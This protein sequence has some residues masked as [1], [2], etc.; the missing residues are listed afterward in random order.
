MLVKVYN[1][2]GVETGTMELSDDVFGCAYNEALVHQA[3]VTNLCNKRQGTKSTLTRAEVRGGGIKPWRQKGTGRARQG[4][5]RSPQWVKGGVVFA[6]K[7]RDFSKKMN[8]KARQIALLSAVSRKIADGQFIVIEDLSLNAAKTKEFAQ[9]CKNLK[10][11]KKTLFVN[12]YDADVL[13][14][15][16][17]IPTVTI[18]TPELISVLE[19]VNNDKIVITK[20]AVMSFQESFIIEEEAIV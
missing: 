1:K 20:E 15:S 8:I 6:P 10:L 3:V 12:N 19:I 13:L 14:A 11:D 2:N 18:V 9:I 7:P 5:T 16:R 4:S 17:N